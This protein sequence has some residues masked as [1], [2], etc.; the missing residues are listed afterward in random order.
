M[1]GKVMDTNMVGSTP[2]KSV[3]ISVQLGDVEN[4]YYLARDKRP[5]SR[6]QL[7]HEISSIL[8][9][10]VTPAEGEMVADVLIELLRQA[11]RDLRQAISE[12]LSLLDGVPLRLVLQMAN[13]EIEI[14]KPVLVQ[15][16]VLGDMDLMYIIKSKTEEYWQA[17]ATRKTLSDQVI[18]VLADTKDFDTSL[19]L[20][21]N[22]SIKL[23]QH[24]M[25]ALSDL[26]RGS[27]VMAMPLLR[28]A[29]VPEDLAIALYKYVGEE[30]KSF[31][32]KNYDVDAQKVSA[33]V[34]QTVGEFGKPASAEDCQP[35]KHMVEA[36]KAANS[37]EMLTVAGMLGTLRRGNLRSFAAQLSVF[38]ELPSD[39][40]TKILMQRNGQGLA[41]LAKAFG[42]E[43]QDFISIFMLT[44]K[45]WN[46]GQLVEPSE[47]KTAVEYY[48]RATPDV[49][50]QIIKGKLQD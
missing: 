36:A 32:T 16:P 39:V 42:I 21:E 34:D 14:A 19:A 48:N 15:S 40:V 4:L 31:I 43:K 27:D 22:E 12:K 26:A 29:E 10:D 47:I 23:T 7:T 8:E 1:W 3:P 9:A 20:A 44:S 25:T 49:A 50:K 37:R 30:I 28:R 24:A 2:K 33:V 18:D 13:D 38:T 46:Q 6:A 11:E 35:E 5:E 45:F 17:I 41:I